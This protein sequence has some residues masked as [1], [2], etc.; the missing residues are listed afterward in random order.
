MAWDP[1][2][3]LGGLFGA[4]GSIYSAERQMQFQR[5]MAKNRYQYMVP[6][7]KAA[8]LNPMLAV[9]GASPPS[10]A[11]GAKAEIAQGAM[12]GVQSAKG[13]RNQKL[14]RELLKNQIHK[15]QADANAANASSAKDISQS[16]KTNW[17]T[18]LLNLEL[19]NAR[20]VAEFYNTPVGRRARQMRLLTD[21]LPIPFLRKGAPGGK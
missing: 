11:P 14:E 7:L 13:A 12:A 4:G 15:T 1:I 18:E 9:G 5:E 19:P 6:D 3:A 10:V 16:V 8:G 2:G 21:Q 17:E 20:A